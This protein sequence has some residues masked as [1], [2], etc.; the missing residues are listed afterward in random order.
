MAEKWKDPVPLPDQE[1]ALINMELDL[2]DFMDALELA[3]GVE[4][5]SFD[6]KEGSIKYKKVAPDKTEITRLY[7]GNSRIKN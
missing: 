7:K 1:E 3:T 2:K 6:E 4:I 5:E